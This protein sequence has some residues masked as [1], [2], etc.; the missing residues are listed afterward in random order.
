MLHQ[1]GCLD[2]TCVDFYVQLD[3]LYILQ[4]AVTPP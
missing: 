1:L 4:K 2:V 3:V